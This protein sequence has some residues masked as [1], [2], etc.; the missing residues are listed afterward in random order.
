MDAIYVATIE[1]GKGDGTNWANATSD[2]RG[3]LVAMANPTGSQ[4]NPYEKN[5]AVYIKAGEYSLPK[6]SAGTAFTVSM[7]TSD[8]FGESLTVKGSYNESGVQDFSQPTIITTQE[9]N[10]N[11]TVSLMDV[12]ANNKPVTIE[13][14]TFINKNTTTAGGTGM[15]AGTTGGKLTLKQVAFRG[16]KANGLNIVPGSSGKILLVNTLFADGGTGLN[17]ADDGTTVVNAT[18]A[19]NTTDLTAASDNV[20]A[21]Y[22]SVS[23]KTV[24]RI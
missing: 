22:N 10:A 18:F 5:K 9:S 24:R 3:A 21:V 15:Q 23:W 11:E 8:E 13:G 6:L 20:P 1:S 14:L 12:E 19:N 16:N 2:I 4:V 7:S 17:G